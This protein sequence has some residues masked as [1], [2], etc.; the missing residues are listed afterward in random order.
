MNITDQLV[1]ILTDKT[2]KKKIIVVSPQSIINWEKGKNSP[3]LKNVD[4]LLEDNNIE[5]F[6]YD[7][8]TNKFIEFAI[9]IGEKEGKKVKVIFEDLHKKKA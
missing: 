3:K 1:Q 4:K 6:L 9:R 8:D 2:K 7:G 5:A